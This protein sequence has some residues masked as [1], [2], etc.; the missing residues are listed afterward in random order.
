MDHDPNNV[1]LF[2]ELC[3]AGILREIASGDYIENLLNV[4]KNQAANPR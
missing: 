3:K 2:G 1:A 4:S